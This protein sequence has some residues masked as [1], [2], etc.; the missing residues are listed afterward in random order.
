[1]GISAVRA[2]I[3]SLQKS[4]NKRAVVQESVVNR[5][6][7]LRERKRINEPHAWLGNLRYTVL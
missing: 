2:S 3:S 4:S 6:N 5:I 1:M 7:V